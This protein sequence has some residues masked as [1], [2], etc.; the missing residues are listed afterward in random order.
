MKLNKIVF[1][2]SLLVMALLSSCEDFLDINTDPNNPASS[3]PQLTLPA[4][5]V[6][7]AVQLEAQYNI[8]GSVLA[9]YW[10]Q[11]PTASQYSGIEQYNITTTNYTGTWAAMYAGNPGAGFDTGVLSDLE[12]VRKAALANGQANYAAVA[13]LLQV[14]AYQILV[15]L[16]DKVPYS[17]ALKGKEGILSPRFDNGDVIYD[18]LVLKI[19]EALSWISVSAPAPGNDDL[20][21]R[22]DM[23][24]WRKF[25]N[26]LKLKIFVRQAL[27][28]PAK[29][30]EGIEEL[31]AANAQFLSTGED[32]RVSFS[33]ATGNENP[34]WQELNL[35]TPQNLVASKTSIDA[36]QNNS[37]SRIQALYDVAPVTGQ[38]DG[39]IQG[40]GTS[41]GGVYNDYARPDAAIILTKSAPVYLM[42][43]YESLFL[44]AEAVQ[45]G[46]GSGSAKALYDAAVL[47]SFA[48][49]GLNGS[50]MVG[51]GGEY[52]Y[53]NA[54]ATIYYQ[55]WLA[56]NGKQGYEGWTEWRRTGVPV[57]Q[58]SIQGAPLTN[59]F[60]LRLI[61]PTNE[62]SSNP[63]VP[64]LTTV[65]T[66]V[67]WDTTF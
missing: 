44:Q 57:L 15:D 53:D 31:Y 40:T 8:L 49:W 28:R 59:V 60:P 62:V 37:D 65:D 20:I 32:A 12:F 6:Q 3:T 26:T 16:Y 33:T 67:W 34:L 58:K 54:L 25:G 35:T 36:L 64:A 23:T 2:Y 63:N 39:L 41:A 7:L 42:T 52:E 47:A 48:F 56:F 1:G 11:G 50:A 43:G 38:Y 5:Q 17:E 18:D 4:A 22:G 61:W 30:Q 46:W 45:R 10:T 13:Q 51:A 21:F 24:L 66:P 29:A 19:D 14:Y 27:A 9:H 55:K